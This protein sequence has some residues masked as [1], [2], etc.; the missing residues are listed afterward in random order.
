MNNIEFDP[1]KGGYKK[2]CPICKK[3]FYG[4]ENK[5]YC[6]DKCKSVLNYSL[7]KNRNNLI[8]S[9]KEIM[10]KDIIILQKLYKK[11]NEK[12]C[13]VNQF[14]EEGFITNVPYIQITKEDG[15]KWIVMGQYAY[16]YIDKENVIIIKIK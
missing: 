13:P 9:E 10:L 16:R 2:T 1:E 7:Y 4:R 3:V 5:V 12:P 14:L 15:T 6:G 11:Y 8:K